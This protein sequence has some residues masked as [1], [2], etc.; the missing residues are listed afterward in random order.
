MA[1]E[2]FD[3]IEIDRRAHDYVKAGFYR[4]D[5]IIQALID[6]FCDEVDEG[7]LRA[8]AV[9]AVDLAIRDQVRAQEFWPV[10][11]DCDRLD[12][13][14]ENL[15]DGGIVARQN[16]TCCQN[17]G[18][19]EI[20][21]EVDGAGERGLPV[22]GYTFYHQQDTERAAADSE[23]YLAYGA[24]GHDDTLKV[25]RAIVVAIESCGLRTE[26]NGSVGQRIRVALNWQRRFPDD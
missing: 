9:H 8:M 18:H 26:W 16:F 14:F 25:A 5:E 20:G 2:D 11:T 21:D 22:H 19:A 23:L 6:E 12:Q 4:R 15:E 24:V 13:A 17:C 3:P 1:E 7:R 10:L